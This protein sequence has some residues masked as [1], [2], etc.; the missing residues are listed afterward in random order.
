M[1]KRTLAIVFS[2]ALVAATF[3]AVPQPAYA[4]T[5]APAK[6]STKSKKEPAKKE[7]KSGDKSGMS[8]A[9]RRTKCSEEW[10]AAKAAGKTANQKWPQFYS[11]CNTRLKGG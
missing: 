3:I 6:E 4:Q 7:T 2:G 1:L 5:V 8:G 11:A 9:E 10:K